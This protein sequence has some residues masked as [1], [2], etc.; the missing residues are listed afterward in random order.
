MLKVNELFESENDHHEFFNVIA[1]VRIIFL[2]TSVF[3]STIE[4]GLSFSILKIADTALSIVFGLLMVTVVNI[5]LLLFYLKTVKEKNNQ[6]N[7]LIYIV[8][9]LSSVYGILG[10]YAYFRYI[11]ELQVLTISAVIGMIGL[12]DLIIINIFIGSFFL[13]GKLN[14]RLVEAAIAINAL[15]LILLVFI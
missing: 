4:P 12:I 10:I 3:S 8:E 15:I 6:S 13:Q 5:A 14:D 9:V 11:Q 2:V 7:F 1:G